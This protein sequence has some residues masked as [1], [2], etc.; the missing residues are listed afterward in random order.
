MLVMVLLP[1]F[2]AVVITLQFV[3]GVNRLGH[4]FRKL[5]GRDASS[6]IL[7]AVVDAETGRPQRRA[8]T[9][10]RFRGALLDVG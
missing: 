2:F 8:A 6:M 10:G 7:A 4:E 9:I 3:P 5:D 1:S